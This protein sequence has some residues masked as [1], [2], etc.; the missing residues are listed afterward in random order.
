MYWNGYGHKYLFDI[1]EV[2]LRRLAIENF[3]TDILLD[4]LRNE[5]FL[6]NYHRKKIEA[7][8]EYIISQGV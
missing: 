8:W 3:D 4:N 2:H 5:L 1:N 7:A 6:C